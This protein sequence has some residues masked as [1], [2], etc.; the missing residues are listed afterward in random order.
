[1]AGSTASSSAACASP[2]L[3]AAVSCEQRG[4]GESRTRSRRRRCR[5]KIEPK[6]RLGLGAV[7]VER[8]LARH[9][10]GAKEVRT[11]R[12]APRT[13]RQRRAAHADAS[14]PPGAADPALDGWRRRAEV[15]LLDVDGARR[16]RQQPVQSGGALA[17]PRDRRRR[18]WNASSKGGRRS[19]S[20]GSATCQRV[21]RR[22]SSGPRGRP[23]LRRTLRHAVATATR[24][25]ELPQLGAMPARGGDA[26]PKRE[27]LR[28]EPARGRRGAQDRQLAA[29]AA[30]QEMA[31]QHLE[32]RR[33]SPPD[34]TGLYRAP[35]DEGRASRQSR[36]RAAPAKKA[37]I[38]R[39]R[40]SV[41]SSGADSTL[42]PAGRPPVAQG[43]AQLPMPVL[44]AKSRRPRCPTAPRIGFG[45]RR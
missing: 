17:A 26:R 9:V 12:A 25:S 42:A 45:G 22:R 30:L 39:R 24:R 37:N 41:R 2:A 14:A 18:R 28:I 33:G 23:R 15:A 8:A 3:A 27:L 10:G 1:M 16:V 6:R 32:R 43:V 5:R 31:A 7:V 19:L 40:A 21:G 36:R 13:A 29:P 35:R 34:R 4:C 11:D 38:I 20:I 44:A